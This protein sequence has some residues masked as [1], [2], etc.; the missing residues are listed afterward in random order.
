MTSGGRDS[1]CEESGNSREKQALRS[2]VHS[3]TKLGKPM[4]H[5]GGSPKVGREGG[6]RRKEMMKVMEEW[7][8][9]EKE[10]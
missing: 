3:S 10:M 6:P 8:Q 4:E 1:L 2:D 5:P 7:L 9:K